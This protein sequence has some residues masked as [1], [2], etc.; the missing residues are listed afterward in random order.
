MNKNETFLRIHFGAD[1]KN[2][3]KVEGI[4]EQYVFN[5]QERVGEHMYYHRFSHEFKKREA[6]VFVKHP[7]FIWYT[8]RVYSF[9]DKTRFYLT[10]AICSACGSGL[11]AYDLEMLFRNY[12]FKQRI[13]PMV[14]PSSK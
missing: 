13:Y 1:Y 8:E 11:S 14:N 5:N 7:S 2:S 3:V 6:C 12:D 4:C 10:I 9:F